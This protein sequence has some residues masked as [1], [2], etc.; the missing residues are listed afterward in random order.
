MEDFG[1]EVV[2]NYNEVALIA[3]PHYFQNQDAL[4]DAILRRLKI[5][6]WKGNSLINIL[7][8][9]SGTGITTIRLVFLSIRARVIAIDCSE[10]MNRMAKESVG[11]LTDRVM[12]LQEDMLDFLQDTSDQYDIFCSGST[13]HNFVKSKWQKVIS[14]AYHSLKP[15]GIF[16]VMDLVARDNTVL[17]QAD[18][19]WEM[20]QMV[21]LKE[22]DEELYYHWVEHYKRDQT[23]KLQEGDLVSWLKKVDFHDI[24]VD[25]RDHMNAV[26]TAVK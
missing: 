18:F 5:A 9:G 4:F 15:G 14:L 23:R 2:K 3:W 25:Y 19:Q 7:E 26:V 24:R 8:A 22:R 20:E 10:E 12:F 11:Y 17:Y 21:K 1:E 16:A 13:L 6:N